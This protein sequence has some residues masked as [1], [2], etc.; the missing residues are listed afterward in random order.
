MND[1]VYGL[2]VKLSKNRFKSR[3]DANYLEYVYYPDKLT[4]ER[5]REIVEGLNKFLQTGDYMQ[6]PAPDRVNRSGKFDVLIDGR[7][8][9][10]TAKQQAANDLAQQM[11]VEG[12]VEVVT[13]TEGLTGR[14]AKAKGWYDVRTG[15][16]TIVLPNNKNADRKSVV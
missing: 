8:T 2:V 13:S 16:V 9:S 5:Q 12:E 3:S 1:D 6:L 11:H 14:Q 15:R 10:P 4:G 7:E